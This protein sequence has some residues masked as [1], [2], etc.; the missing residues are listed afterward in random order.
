MLILCGALLK[1]SVFFGRLRHAAGSIAEHIYF[2]AEL[3]ADFHHPQCSQWRRSL[4]NPKPE[5]SL[6]EG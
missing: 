6:L 1:V 4:A 5:Y 3:Y 2:D